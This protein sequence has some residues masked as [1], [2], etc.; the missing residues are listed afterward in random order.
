MTEK[1]LQAK[2]IKWLKEKKFY[3]IKTRPGAGTPVGCPDIIAVF[4]DFWLA[5]EVKASDHAKFQPGQE[6]TLELLRQHSDD[7]YVVHPD[8][9]E[10]V[11]AKID[12][13][14]F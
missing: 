13:H 4:G 3:V 5:I 7:V 11:Q 10:D 1:Q 8:N 14:F 9:W 12:K 2:I 6:I